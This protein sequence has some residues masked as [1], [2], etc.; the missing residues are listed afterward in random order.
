MWELVRWRPAAALPRPDGGGQSALCAKPYRRPGWLEIV[1]V[2]LNAARAGL[3]L[4]MA[5]QDCAAI[6]LRQPDA[7]GPWRDVR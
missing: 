4:I 6:D 7:C 1:G 3:T 5:A 2:S